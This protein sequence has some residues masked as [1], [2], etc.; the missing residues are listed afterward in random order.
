MLPGGG[1]H[2]VSR[3][4][5]SPARCAAGRLP[6][7]AA[8]H[9]V[10]TVPGAASPAPPGTPP[11]TRGQALGTRDQG[12]L[13]G[14]YILDFAMTVNYTPPETVPRIGMP[15]MQA[16]SEVGLSCPLAGLHGAGELSQVALLYLQG[17]PH[18][19]ATTAAYLGNTGFPAGVDTIFTSCLRF[20]LW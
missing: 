8:T 3:G 17:G 1:R 20:F 14:N 2:G 11:F 6:A 10:R 15:F 19:D 18:A 4:S 13:F 5:V 9:P 16:N 12:R 7:I